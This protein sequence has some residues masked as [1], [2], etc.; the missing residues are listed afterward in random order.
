MVML[1]AVEN[2]KSSVFFWFRAVSRDT[3]W[4]ILFLGFRHTVDLV[5]IYVFALS[6]F[7]SCGIY[8]V[9]RVLL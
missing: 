1:S 7:L 4:T 3:R 6:T 9:Y 2:T 8:Y 5:R